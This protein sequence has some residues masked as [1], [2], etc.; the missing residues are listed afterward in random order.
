MFIILLCLFFLGG[1]SG[2]EKSEKDKL[3]EQN[4]KGEYIY[5]HENEVLY[6]IASP[7][8]REREPYPWEVAEK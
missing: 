6:P 1:C 4:A 3:R 2:L 8:P 5:R 7:R